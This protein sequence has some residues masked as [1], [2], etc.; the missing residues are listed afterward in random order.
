[1][2]ISTAQHGVVVEVIAEGRI[3]ES[4]ADHLASALDDVVR[5]GPITSV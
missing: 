5:R 2:R 1:M 4:W 3:D